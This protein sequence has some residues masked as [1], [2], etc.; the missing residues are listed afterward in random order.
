MIYLD[1]AANYP[2]KKEVLDSLVQTELSFPGNMNST[3]ALGT[4]SFAEYERLNT[5]ILKNLGLDP[6]VYEAIYTSSGTESNNLAIKGIYE[7]YSGFGNTILSSEFEH[8]STNAALAH[9]KDKGAEV[10]LV[11]TDSNGKIDYEEL[12]GKWN[13]DTLLLCLSLVESEAGAIQDYSKIQDFISSKKKGYLLLDAT[14][15][16]GKFPV[17]L[18]GIDMISFTPHK[19]GGLIGTGVL[20]KKKSIVLTP[21]IHG[22]KSASVYRSGTVPLGLISS[23]YKSLQIAYENMRNNFVYVSDM[24]NY[25]RD[26]LKQIPYIQIN[27]GND[28]P[29]ITNFSIENIPGGKTVDYLSSKGICISQKSA[30]SVPNTPSK[31]INAIYHDKRRALSSVRVSI[32]DLTTKEEIDALLDALKEIKP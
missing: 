22:G 3:H 10:L 6:E 32:S 30:C 28:N 31:V 8:S 14:Q 26:G 5:E 17:Q 2:T 20:I 4:L 16:I 12:K 27:S 1:Y 21:L 9:L 19:F 7:S 15:A 13:S 25:L 24:C 11:G 29:Y 18:N 23:I